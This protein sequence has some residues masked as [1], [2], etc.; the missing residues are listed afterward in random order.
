M[1]YIHNTTE[2]QSNPDTAPPPHIAP[3]SLTAHDKVCEQE[4][5]IIQYVDLP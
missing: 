1:N 5:P 3:P 2:M 4:S